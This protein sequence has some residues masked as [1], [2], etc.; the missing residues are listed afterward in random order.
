MSYIDKTWSFEV[1][2]HVYLID[3]RFKLKDLGFY[4]PD[5][6]VET[7]VAYRPGKFVNE[8][9]EIWYDDR[10]YQ[11]KQCLV[12]TF[13]HPIF[14]NYPVLRRIRGHFHIKY[15]ISTNAIRPYDVMEKSESGD[16]FIYASLAHSPIVTKV[17]DVYEELPKNTTESLIEIT[18][19]LTASELERLT[20]DVNFVT[21][22][23]ERYQQAESERYKQVS[24]NF[25][26]NSRIIA[27]DGVVMQLQSY[28]DTLLKN[29]QWALDKVVALQ[30]STKE[31]ISQGISLVEGQYNLGVPWDAITM[32]DM[33]KT[34]A[35]MQAD[36]R[37]F[38]AMMKQNGTLSD[39]QKQVLAIQF[40]NVV[41][42]DWMRN[43][44]GGADPRTII[45]PV[46]MHPLTISKKPTPL[47]L[48]ITKAQMFENN[49]M[50]EEDFKRASLEYLNQM[51]EEFKKEPNSA[52]ETMKQN[53][54]KQIP[55]AT[56]QQQEQ[57]R[58]LYATTR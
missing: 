18:P 20:K 7:E 24:Q 6:G 38:M 55:A 3:D 54:L 33:S 35:I 13:K 43:F 44:M 26:L 52:V 19:H 8:L 51:Q 53:I 45:S 14:G 32:E 11:D 37:S 30:L 34:A 2:P 12:V 50:T 39:G 42:V 27:S 21:T 48:F 25:I 41:G 58:E 49:T 40:L 47:E 36:I 9:E 23:K 46:G 15:I 28:V 10:K 56:Q 1:L 5:W 22:I 57:K 16:L 31:K 17:Y 29:Y 4:D